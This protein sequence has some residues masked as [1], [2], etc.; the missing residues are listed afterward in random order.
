MAA[1][2]AAV[3]LVAEEPVCVAEPFYLWPENS[4]VFDLWLSLQ[5]QWTCESGCRIGLNYLGVEACMRLRGMARR[6]R[7]EQFLMIQQMEFSMLKD[8]AK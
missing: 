6:Q 2:L 3:G 1:A 5:T 4:Q 8:W 7:E